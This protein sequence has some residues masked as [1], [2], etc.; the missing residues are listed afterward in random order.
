[1]DMTA[2]QDD[3]GRVLIVDDRGGLWSWQLSV[4]AFGLEE[5]L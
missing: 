1:M 3:W 4:S 2:D 5:D